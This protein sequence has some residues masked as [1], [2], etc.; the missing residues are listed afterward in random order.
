MW[1]RERDKKTFCSE[2]LL[3]ELDDNH[4]E[5]I[6]I[7]DGPTGCGKSYILKRLGERTEVLI[8][9]VGFIKGPLIKSFRESGADDPLSS[10]FSWTDSALPY[11]ILA[12]EDADVYLGGMPLTQKATARAFLKLAE[13]RKIILTGINLKKNCPDLL[14]ELTGSMSFYLFA[15]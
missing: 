15:G 8:R 9:P 4:D 3:K 13:S 14:E 11:Q 7:L 1:L 6:A 2:T 5:K 12:F 10:F